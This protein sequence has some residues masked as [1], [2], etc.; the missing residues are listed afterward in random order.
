M[1]LF[2]FYDY[3]Q[4]IQFYEFLIERIQNNFYRPLFFLLYRLWFHQIRLYVS[5]PPQHHSIMITPVILFNIIL[6]ILFRY[7]LLCKEKNEMNTYLNLDEHRTCSFLE[8]IFCSCLV[9]LPLY[10]MRYLTMI[11]Y[12]SLKV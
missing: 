7:Y 10:N 3:F 2:S 8:M 1:E 12:V 11:S 9:F 5:Q 4:I 6:Y